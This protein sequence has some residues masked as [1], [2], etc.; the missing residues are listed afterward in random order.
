VV[1]V[2]AL[3]NSVFL[4][5][6]TVEDTGFMRL[7]RPQAGIGISRSISRDWLSDRSIVCHS[8][9]RSPTAMAGSPAGVG[10]QLCSFLIVL[11]I[12]HFRVSRIDFVLQ[13]FLKRCVIDF[14]CLESLESK[15]ANVNVAPF[16]LVVRTD[17]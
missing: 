16:G 13:C 5:V 12:K 6:P 8:P 7:E 9:C 2:E 14:Q 11:L 4:R 15:V 10:T 17:D 1:M 3:Q